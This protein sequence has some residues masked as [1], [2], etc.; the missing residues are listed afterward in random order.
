MDT[1]PE[2]IGVERTKPIYA[3]KKLFT[4]EKILHMTY[5]YVEV[6]M[7][8]MGSG[9]SEEVPFHTVRVHTCGKFTQVSIT[10]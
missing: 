1:H 10:F 5:T 3:C 6:L 8:T 9:D 4:R 7:E 2:Q